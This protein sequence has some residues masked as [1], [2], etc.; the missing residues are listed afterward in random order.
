MKHEYFI[1]LLPNERTFRGNNLWAVTSLYRYDIITAFRPADRVFTFTWTEYSKQQCNFHLQ[2]LTYKIV[3]FNNNYCLA[4]RAVTSMKW[5]LFFPQ[6]LNIL[7]L[8]RL[9]DS[10]PTSLGFALATHKHT[11]KEFERVTSERLP[12]LKAETSRQCLSLL[13]SSGLWI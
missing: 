10:G 7:L 9:V 6:R 13:V 5:Q 2:R 8:W 3:S 11:T 1:G 4:F 12:N